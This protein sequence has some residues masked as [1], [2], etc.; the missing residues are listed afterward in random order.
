L[1]EHGLS[2]WLVSPLQ[3]NRSFLRHQKE[4]ELTHI[5]NK[6]MISVLAYLDEM[7]IRLKSY[8]DN[9]N[10]V[11]VSLL[12]DAFIF[13]TAKYSIQWANIH[14]GMNIIRIQLGWNKHRAVENYVF[15]FA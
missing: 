9:I 1:E 8:K 13:I 2:W 7:E 10:V 6:R 11:Q 12:I 5:A 14:N 15:Q 3:G 4:L